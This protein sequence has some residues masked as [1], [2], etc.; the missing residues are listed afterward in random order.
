[1]SKTMFCAITVI[2]SIRS[3]RGVQFFRDKGIVLVYESFS[4]NNLFIVKESFYD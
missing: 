2:A 3:M 4:Y 1:M